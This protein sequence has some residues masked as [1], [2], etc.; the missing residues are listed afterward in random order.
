MLRINS[1]TTRAV[2]AFDVVGLFCI[3]GMPPYGFMPQLRH[4]HYNALHV[5]CQDDAIFFLQK[6]NEKTAAQ[7]FTGAAIYPKMQGN[8]PLYPHSTHYPH[9]VK[10]FLPHF[11]TV[12][13]SCTQPSP[14]GHRSFSQHIPPHP[15]QQISH[16]YGQ[17]G[18][19]AAGMQTYHQ[20]GYT[21]QGTHLLSEIPSHA[22]WKTLIN[23]IRKTVSGFAGRYPILR[24]GRY[25]A[26]G[27]E[28]S[29]ARIAEERIFALHGGASSVC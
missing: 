27:K 20:A 5:Y 10:H 19:S 14:S 15:R 21:A 29:V 11:R 17:A 23:G 28:I 1:T 18:S 26:L 6:T 3:F 8:H 2:T 13:R 4:A 16:P 12:P 25:L 24:I 9:F 7:A 22:F